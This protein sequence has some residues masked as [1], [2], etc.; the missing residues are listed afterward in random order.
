MA[1]NCA[2][3]GAWIGER[4]RRGVVLG[5]LGGAAL[6]STGGCASSHVVLTPGEIG[7]KGARSFATPPSTVF[8]A[9]TG[10]LL[11]DGYEIERSDPEQGVIVTKPLAVS[12]QGPVTARSYRITI[13][14]DGHGGSRMVAEPHLYAGGRDVSDRELWN[15]DGPRGEVAR[16]N[17]L[18]TDVDSVVI[19]PVPDTSEREALAKTAVQQTDV[20]GGGKT[21]APQPGLTPATL[22]PAPRAPAR[23]S[24]ATE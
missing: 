17:D 5:M 23:P 14:P 2:G 18:F 13:A 10:A 3:F 4:F 11:A 6:A 16:W 15:L 21:A 7:R 12:G 8:Y 9:C 24:P 22:G 1:N 19:G 20:P